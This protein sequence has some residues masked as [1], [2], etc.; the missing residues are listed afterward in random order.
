MST[1]F[2]I[3]LACPWNFPVSGNGQQRC[4]GF[5]KY[6][7]CGSVNSSHGYKESLF[8]SAER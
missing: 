7:G 4:S 3:L 1:G 6:L 2:L 8:A 5:S